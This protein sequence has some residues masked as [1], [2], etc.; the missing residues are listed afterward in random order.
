[1]QGANRNRNPP[2]ASGNN[3]QGG[4]DQGSSQGDTRLGEF[5]TPAKTQRFSKGG[6]DAL[7]IHDARYVM[8]RLPT[9]NP[10]GPGGTTVIDPN[11]TKA[12]APY[13]NAPLKET[14]SDAPPDERQLVPPRYRDLIH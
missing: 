3:P 1:M 11:R 8:F 9:V 5:P 7:S 6:S 10:V 14:S 2:Q 12:T 13:V 4:R